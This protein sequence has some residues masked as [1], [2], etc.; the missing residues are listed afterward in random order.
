MKTNTPLHKV[1]VAAKQWCGIS[2]ARRLHHFASLRATHSRL[3]T[4]FGYSFTSYGV[5]ARAADTTSEVFDATPGVLSASSGAGLEV[6]PR[7]VL[8]LA[9]SPQLREDGRRVEPRRARELR[10]PRNGSSG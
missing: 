7:V 10:T 1:K 6:L 3:A 2:R 8:P 4:S 9:A 5:G